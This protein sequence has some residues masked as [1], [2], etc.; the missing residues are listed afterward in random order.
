MGHRAAQSRLRLYRALE[1][2]LR[3]SPID[4][5]HRECD[6][7]CRTVVRGQKSR[8]QPAILAR[9]LPDAGRISAGLVGPFGHRKPRRSMRA[10]QRR[11]CGRPPREYPRAN[12]PISGPKFRISW[13]NAE[14]GQS[15]RKRELSSNVRVAVLASVSEKYPQ[16]PLHPRDLQSPGSR[17]YCRWC[18]PVLEQLL[19]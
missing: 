5:R 13:R 7:P 6:P 17:D 3:R 8:G 12:I 4:P 2:P 18:R 14:N 1:S 11:F 15:L 19:H 9:I 16:V 10:G